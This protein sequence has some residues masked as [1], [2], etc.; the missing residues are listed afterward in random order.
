MP[1]SIVCSC[2]FYENFSLHAAT[3]FFHRSSHTNH[4]RD[5]A[6][7]TLNSLQTYTPEMLCE[8]QHK[9]GHRHCS[10]AMYPF[11]T[12]F[13]PYDTAHTVRAFT[14]LSALYGSYSA[15]SLSLQKE[16]VLYSESVL[17][18]YV[19]VVSRYNH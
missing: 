6:A 18:S 7:A 12:D 14:I 1:T 17:R 19:P 5:S 8:L 16:V 15:D 11:M 10:P 13:G 4:V 2:I 3:E 9:I